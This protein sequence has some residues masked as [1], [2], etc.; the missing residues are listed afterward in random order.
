MSRPV[1]CLVLLTIFATMTPC[2]CEA[3]ILRRI[4][5]RRAALLAPPAEPSPAATDADEAAADA[6]APPVRGGFLARRLQL[7]RDLVAQQEALESPT[8][9][10]PAAQ[11]QQRATQARQRQPF[12]T[13]RQASAAEA[14]MIRALTEDD[15][16]RME[17]P[18]LQ[19]ALAD[20]NAAL[21]NELNQFTSAASWQRYFDLPSGVVEHGT[22][23][24]TALQTLLQRHE[25]VSENPNYSQ[26]ASLPGFQQ[27]HSLLAALA[28]RAEPPRIE[29]SATSVG[30]Q[31]IN[32]TGATEV[33]AEAVEALPA[34]E[35]QSAAPQRPRAEGEHSILK[36]NS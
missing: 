32:P 17:V 11:S 12:E 27:S 25:R 14:P 9:A 26:I 34:P 30:P 1:V 18:E 35:P 5:E 24:L 8:P 28:D 16:S 10:S 33:Q 19:Q 3:Q 22:V 2:E 31:L 20:T 23:D 13:M 4:R 7:R 36:R 21:T 29:S 15:I 6:A